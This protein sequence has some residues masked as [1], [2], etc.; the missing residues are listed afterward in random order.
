M[1]DQT[2]QDI[3]NRYRGSAPP[4]GPK[5]FSL[6]GPLA[7]GQHWNDNW[8][9]GDLTSF[10]RYAL[11]GFPTPY[12]TPPAVPDEKASADAFQL[13]LIQHLCP[14]AGPDTPHRISSAADRALGHA[15]APPTAVLVRA[16]LAARQGH[17]GTDF[18]VVLGL[19]TV[20][21][22]RVPVPAAVWTDA[23]GNVAV[24]PFQTAPGQPF[25]GTV[26]PSALPL[27]ANGFPTLEEWGARKDTWWSMNGAAAFGI[28]AVAVPG[29]TFGPALSAIF[30]P[31]LEGML[32][33]LA[34]SPAGEHH[35]PTVQAP[36]L[37]VPTMLPLPAHHGL[38]I[39]QVFSTA[40]SVPALKGALTA[41]G[42]VD[43]PAWLDHPIV[44]TW[45]GL[46]ASA[47]A[48][49]PLSFATGAS[50]AALLQP[51]LFRATGDALAETAIQFA[52][53]MRFHTVQRTLPKAT[54]N[55]WAQYLAK[56]HPGTFD[57]ELLHLRDIP[58]EYNPY[59][60]IVRPPETGAWAARYGYAAWETQEAYFPPSLRPY[61][62][63]K[64]VI[65]KSEKE[66]PRLPLMTW[67]DEVAARDALAD[68]AST[69]IRSPAGIRTLAPTNKRARDPT[70]DTTTV[71]RR[72]A[73]ATDTTQAVDLTSDDPAHA[74]FTSHRTSPRARLFDSRLLSAT[75]ASQWTVPAA[76]AHASA[77]ETKRLA[78][79]VWTFTT[80]NR[81][82]PDQG[83]YHALSGLLATHDPTFLGMTPDGTPIAAE[84]Y[85]FPGNINLTFRRDFLAQMDAAQAG[86]WLRSQYLEDH[87][88]SALRID[89]HPRFFDKDMIDILRKETH[90]G[91][92]LTTDDLHRGTSALVWYRSL[93]SSAGPL[94]SSAGP[95]IEDAATLLA[96]MQWFLELSVAE[97]GPPDVQDWR[98]APDETP[99]QRSLLHTALQDLTTYLASRHLQR[100]WDDTV[101]TR[102]RHF[103]VFACLIHQIFALFDRWRK[104]DSI[105]QAIIPARDP[106]KKLAGLAVRIF[107]RHT[108]SSTSLLL[109]VQRWRS[110]A[111][112]VFSGNPY[113]Q[114]Q[115]F[116]QEPPAEFF[117]AT[118]PARY[119][120]QEHPFGGPQTPAHYPAPRQ[121]QPPPPPSYHHQQPQA[122]QPPP[123]PRYDQRHPAQTPQPPPRH[124]APPPAQAPIQAASKSLFQYAQAATA[125]SRAFGAAT[126][127]MKHIGGRA[128]IL[129]TAGVAHHTNDKQLCLAFCFQGAPWSGCRGNA[130]GTRAC[131]RLHLDCARAHE[132]PP[133]AVA[134][135]IAW[136]R[137]DTVRAHVAPTAAL[138]ATEWW[139]QNP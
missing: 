79:S 18:L 35:P 88:Q 110:E 68:E 64:H 50:I 44:T 72:Q 41:M 113:S 89:I 34:A 2:P 135:L 67:D 100:A 32:E 26:A 19:P 80:A 127:F 55:A 119:P 20:A 74:A 53:K 115:R 96:N 31:T 6:A 132:L 136:L 77:A 118:P 10:R 103:Y 120:Y 16:T 86:T 107:D 23:T 131:H 25:I 43:T 59:L 52:G 45:L 29:Q 85:L 125:E 134:P 112:D 51:A 39:G 75:P 128:P 38:P 58:P 1:V 37:L 102:R 78:P 90:S 63:S 7:A 48:P 108:R 14:A 27:V 61:L 133:R 111:Q 4:F 22:D 109:E 54:N 21:L 93:P 36:T 3:L 106:G 17:Q 94:F 124:H 137:S 114:H 60:P 49:P 42:L 40:I 15:R 101:A 30:D 24:A 138:L 123:P 121:S 91:Q 99:F 46:Q 129:A 69:P 66:P 84:Q 33:K 8:T 81:N 13:M 122:Y 76:V 97:F 117:D 83:C 98:R 139:A 73:T 12:G 57:T 105:V 92:A 126:N 87:Q 56:A 62:Q 65:R 82:Y 104:Q 70:T 71:P 130:R 95:T 5:V 28:H 9:V 11:S 47:A 116:L